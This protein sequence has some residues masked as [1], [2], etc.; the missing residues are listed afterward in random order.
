V[1]SKPGAVFLS[2]LPH[3]GS[4]RLAVLVRPSAE[5]SGGDC[6]PRRFVIMWHQ[7]RSFSPGSLSGA[8]SAWESRQHP[9]YS[10]IPL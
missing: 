3:I 10:G 8:L 5:R 6:L 2:I 1:L 4:A 7:L 9:A